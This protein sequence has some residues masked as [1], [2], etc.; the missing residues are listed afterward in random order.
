MNDHNILEHTI[1]LLSRLQGIGTRSARRILFDLMKKKDILLDP[2]ILSLENLSSNI[3]TC[4]RC[5]NLDVA[6]PCYIC[7]DENR[8]TSLLCIVEDIS[9]LWA[10]EKTKN[11]NGLYFVLSGNISA[12]FGKDPK[13]LH[14]DRLVDMIDDS[15]CLVEEI[16]IATSATLEG[17]ITANYI[18]QEVQDKVKV[19]MLAQGIPMGGE[20]DYLDDV[21]LSTALK[22]RK[23]L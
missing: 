17:Q 16:I 12:S 18:H 4:S 14:I 11:Y 22:L 1:L 10:L 21:T 15:S 5:F 3:C 20:I 2:L 7:R 6:D 13:S 19:S 23:R 9:A 8:D